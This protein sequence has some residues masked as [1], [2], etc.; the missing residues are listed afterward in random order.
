MF[1]RSVQSNGNGSGVGPSRRTEERV[2]PM[3]GIGADATL[4][5]SALDLTAL[6]ASIRFEDRRLEERRLVCLEQVHHAAHETHTKLGAY[7]RHAIS[8]C[9]GSLSAWD[10]EQDATSFYIALANYC[11]AVRRVADEFAP[12]LALNAHRHDKAH[13]DRG[14][15]PATDHR[16]RMAI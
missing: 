12:V 8:E 10:V 13:T 14:N 11:A 6:L 9:R 4:A 16:A 7:T 3:V 5:R 15:G 1:E 2:A